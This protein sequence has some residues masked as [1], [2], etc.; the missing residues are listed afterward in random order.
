MSILLFYAFIFPC[1]E[2]AGGELVDYESKE[3][4]LVRPAEFYV[5]VLKK[6]K[7]VARASGGATILT[8]PM[9][10]R[11]VEMGQL[12]NSAVVELIL[13]KF[14]DHLPIYRQMRIWQRDHGLF[15][16]EA[17]VGRHV[18]SAGRLLGRRAPRR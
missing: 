16:D 5:Q 4:L 9:P 7:R 8:T 11:F 13:A 18:L 3:E 17:L 12:G 14:C 2:G 10:A 15:L 6:E 1:E